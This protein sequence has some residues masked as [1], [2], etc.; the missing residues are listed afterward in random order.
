MKKLY[1]F[2]RESKGNIKWAGPGDNW[3]GV[4]IID[5][6]KLTWSD[7]KE[8]WDH[9]KDNDKLTVICND[10]KTRSKEFRYDFSIPRRGD[11][12]IFVKLTLPGGEVKEFAKPIFNDEDAFRR[13]WN[14]QLELNIKR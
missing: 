3:F 4:K 11:G 9:L 7:L 14:D 10:D 13:F 2:L 6:D 12:K 5:N 8:L 1:D